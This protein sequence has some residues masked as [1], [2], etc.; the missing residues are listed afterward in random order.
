MALDGVESREKRKFSL[1]SR[2][3]LETLKAYLE[4][5][6]QKEQ[7]SPYEKAVYGSLA[8]LISPVIPVCRTYM[9]FIWVYFK[10]LYNHIIDRELR[11]LVSILFE[12]S[13]MFPVN[14]NQHFSKTI[15]TTNLCSR[16]CSNTARH[17]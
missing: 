12:Y 3:I 4:Q 5:I 9:D 15:K 11:Y 2:L 10:A 17:G 13:F 8:G 6:M 7:I 14:N 16:L 1:F